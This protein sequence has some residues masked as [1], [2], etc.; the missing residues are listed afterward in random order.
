MHALLAELRRDPRAERRRWATRAALTATL[1]LS[2]AGAAGA[3]DRS[4]PL[5]VDAGAPLA[6]VWDAE[7][8]AAVTTAFAGACAGAR[9]CDGEAHARVAAQLDEYAAAWTA[10]R[11]AACE[12]T[13]VHGTQ[14]AELLDLRMACLDER[15]RDLDALVD[16]FAAADAE[17]VA[18]A[19]EAAADL[20]SLAPCA[21]AAYL[22]AGLRPPEEPGLQRAVEAVRARFDAAQALGDAGKQDDAAA[23]TQ[24]LLIEATDLGYAPLT[25]ELR[26]EL[27]LLTRAVDPDRSAEHSL[28]A[29]FLARA[30]GHDALA[31]HVATDLV[32]TVGYVLGDQAGG[33]LWIR[34]A[35]AES[36]R[37]GA[38]EDER[39]DALAAVASVRAEQGRNEEA[40]ALLDRAIAERATPPGTLMRSRVEG[41][42]GAVLDALG[43]YEASRAAYERSLAD[44]LRMHGPLH[45]MVA[46]TRTNLGLVL[47]RQGDLDGAIREHEASLAILT[48][49]RGPDH[50][51][52][53]QS[54]LNL[55]IALTAAGRHDE[56][57]A[58]LEEALAITRRML[59]SDHPD[60]ALCLSA[61]ADALRDRGRPGEAIALAQ[62]ALA[63]V[64]A[65]HGPDHPEVAEQLTLIGGALADAGRV[66]EAL[67]MLGRA[68]AVWDRRG[69]S[70]HPGLAEVL[71]DHGELLLRLGRAGE[72]APLLARA[73]EIAGRGEVAAEVAA[74]AR[75]GLARA[76]AG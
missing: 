3:F 48:A 25:A 41:N 56:A 17:V 44:E 75:S 72:A 7:R 20:S 74:R 45:P 28:D 23:A 1:G 61:L 62:E 19:S 76:Q 24:A 64:E 65:I 54:L 66:E 5:C 15:L 60:V 46:L 43:R 50:D 22:L 52:R 69:E 26:A 31:A 12:A 57:T 30:S 29:Y 33:E 16:V 34:H 68:V 42:R 21:D 39:S 67:E 14:S 9:G 11:T 70:M 71:V 38:S 73:V 27:G 51:T 37:R 55:G 4:P 8:A 2:L 36:A 13:H 18:A 59:G 47:M 49:L 53:W 6:G 40:L 10:A 32:W 58:R 63:I 35:L